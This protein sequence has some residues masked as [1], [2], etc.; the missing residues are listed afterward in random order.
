MKTAVHV[1]RGGHLVT[2][3]KTGTKASLCKVT[4]ITIKGRTFMGRRGGRTLCGPSTGKNSPS[5]RA[6]RAAFKAMVRGMRRRGHRRGAAR[7][8]SRR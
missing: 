4:K 1:R 2:F 7:R 6:A 5:S 8:R 3:H